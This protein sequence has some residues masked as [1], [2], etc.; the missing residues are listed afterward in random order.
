MLSG[1]AAEHAHRFPRLLHCLVLARASP[2]PV[3][4]S[5][6]RGLRGSR[7]VGPVGQVFC[8]RALPDLR[9]ALGA[10]H[11]GRTNGSQADD[12]AQRV[13]LPVCLSGP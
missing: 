11:L 1:S 9:H 6:E 4:G 3:G 7:E 10:E 12:A 13:C 5:S 8:Q 2:E